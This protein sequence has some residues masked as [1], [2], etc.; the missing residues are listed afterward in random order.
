MRQGQ[1]TLYCNR[2]I[3]SRTH[4]NVL[5]APLDRGATRIGYAL[6]P[7]ILAKHPGGITEEVAV[8]EAVASMAPFKVR[9]SEVHWWTVYTIGQRIARDFSA[10]DRVFLCGD[11]AHTHSSGAAQ[12]L[13][14]G[15]H[16]A[17]NLAWK[18]ALQIRRLSKAP[19]L[20]TYSAERLTA[21]QKL[22]DYDR[23]ISTLMTH[24]WPSWYTGDRSAD[25]YLILGDIFDKAADFNTGLGITYPANVLNQPSGVQLSVAPGS[26]PPDLDLTMPGTNRSVRLQSVTPNMAKFWVVVFTGK[27]ESTS[28]SLRALSDYLEASPGLKDHAAIGWVTISESVGCST[29]EA[30]GMEPLGSMYF[31]PQGKAHGKI[32]V[33]MGTGCALILRPDGLVGAGGPLSGTWIEGFFSGV[34]N[35]G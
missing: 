23:D 21:V 13:N 28:E 3:E 7:E 31:D 4:G 35:L 19:V 10:K 14:T 20:E 33:D 26:R 9:F 15:I 5:W 29:Y 17:V 32:G 11:A 6:T 2:A 25:P 1:L 22:I 8:E 34:L 16:D 12:G 27:V 18:L 24:K 30:I